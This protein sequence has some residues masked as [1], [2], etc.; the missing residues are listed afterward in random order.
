MNSE[1]K[2][3]G[4]LRRAVGA[5]WAYLVA[6]WRWLKRMRVAI[7]LVLV[8]TVVSIVGTL[9][10]QVGVNP[11][12]VLGFQN[13]RPSLAKV[14]GYL[15]IFDLYGAWWFQLLILLLLASLL[16]C[17]LPRIKRF[18]VHMRAPKTPI[19]RS[20]MER[21]V[22][23]VSFTPKV[24][25]SEAL[26]RSKAVLK[27]HRFRMWSVA[28]S[29]DQIYAE[30]N[31]F[32]ELGSILFHLSFVLLMVGIVYGKLNGFEGSA[33]IIEGDTWVE[34]H[35]LYDTIREGLWF[36]E[37][38]KGFNVRVDDYKVEYYP[39]GA[40]S[41]FQTTLSVFDDGRKVKTRTVFVNGKL[42]YKG[43]KFYQ[44]SYGWAPRVTVT[45]DG[46]VLADGPVVSLGQPTFSQGVVKIPAAGPPPNQVG[47][48]FFFVPDPVTAQGRV[49]G[50]SPIPNDPTLYFRV[51]RGDLG[52]TV[53]QSVYSLD[54]TNLTLVTEGEVKLNGETE[55]LDGLEVA[56]PEL[57]EWTGLQISKDPGIPT[58]YTA[59]TLA[60]IG[61]MVAFYF[62][63]R[64][65]W[66]LAVPD[67]KKS[68]L[69]IGGLSRHHKA[70]SHEF[71]HL[72]NDLKEV[73]R[74]KES[75]VRT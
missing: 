24:S 8:L 52:L 60:L 39:S 12:G 68:Q 38:H 67:G 13:S 64:R 10:P 46:K 47:I 4:L 33:I 1:V 5:I 3:E 74:R 28:G 55:I 61:V 66:V 72:E 41:N 18:Y 14:F 17:L 32:H 58:I 42:I 7:V 36:G 53:P 49:F 15:G 20:F 45:K 23:R 59:F 73:L 43:V 57:K 6:T 19:T 22:N 35:A 51:Y 65:V 21:L 71:K 11:S 27:K 9:I 56:F 34:G 26:E 75:K 29:E 69:F 40:P 70:F 44:S 30:K 25:T 62:P 50:N 63:N 2:K 54:T 31:R 37:Q 48:E 16:S